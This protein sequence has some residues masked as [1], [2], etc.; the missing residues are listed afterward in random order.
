MDDPGERL[1]PYLRA[2][3]TLRWCGRPDPRVLL[4]RPDA[5]L[6]PFGLLWTAL[7]VAVVVSAGADPVPLVIGA[8]FIVAGLYVV[9]GRY[10]L[11]WRRKRRTAYGV[12][13]RRMLVAVGD[14]IA[15]ADLD[16]ENLTVVHARDA[17]HASVI[18]ES[19]AS[20][21]RGAATYANTGLDLRGRIE[22]GDTAFYD[23]AD[24]E[25]ML[26]AVRA[27]AATAPKPI[28]GRRPGS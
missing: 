11:K 10:L 19:S 5:F 26:V 8:V 22:R 13:E 12:T 25:P 3:E 7:M 23:V 14:S 15:A 17:K 21:V 16:Y 6:L 27:A 9:A 4:S 20:A 24:V 1:R 28:P 18:P 2:D